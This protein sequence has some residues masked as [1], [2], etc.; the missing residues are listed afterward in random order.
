MQLYRVIDIC[1]KINA[2]W[3]CKLNFLSGV[4]QS[5]NTMQGEGAMAK[6]LYN[7]RHSPNPK[8]R[9]QNPAPKIPRETED[10]KIKGCLRKQKGPE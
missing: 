8:S 9:T 4:N 7:T 2:E 3:L 5:Q 10:H 1:R 6:W